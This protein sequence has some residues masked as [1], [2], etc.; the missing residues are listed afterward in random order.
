M[1]VT[2]QS[3]RSGQPTYAAKKRVEGPTKGLIPSGRTDEG[4]PRTGDSYFR[5]FANACRANRRLFSNRTTP[6][7]SSTARCI[8]ATLASYMRL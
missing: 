3:P 7:E 5:G 6:G 4:P 1:R 2:F 8:L